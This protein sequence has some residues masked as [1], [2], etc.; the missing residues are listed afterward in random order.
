MFM[1][2]KKPN[3]RRVV[4][5]AVGLVGAVLLAIPIAIMAV[6]ARLES[7]KSG[8]FRQS[9][10]G[11]HGKPFTIYKIRTLDPKLVPLRVSGIFRKFALD[12]F[13]QVINLLK[14]DMSIIGPRPYYYTLPEWSRLLDITPGL[15]GLNG[16]DE[17]TKGVTNTPEV[18]AKIEGGY[19]DLRLSAHSSLPADLRIF[20]RTVQIVVTGRVD[21]NN[22]HHDPVVPLSSTSEPT[23]N[24][25]AETKKPSLLPTSDL[26]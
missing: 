18:R 25:I 23:R 4:D 8:I 17:K 20:F 7:G 1:H 2:L 13:P 12:E 15:M 9:R 11:L 24:D 26:T 19:V 22:Q 6:I 14:G 10:Y 5:F 21:I 3:L 16:L